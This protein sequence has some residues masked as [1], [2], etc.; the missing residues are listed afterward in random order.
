MILYMYFV[1]KIAGSDRALH[2]MILEMI[3]YFTLPIWLN[4]LIY[5]RLRTL[6]GNL[7]HWNLSPWLSAVNMAPSIVI[8]SSLSSLIPLLSMSNF[9]KERKSL[10]IMFI[11]G[12]AGSLYLACVYASQTH[13]TC[14]LVRS[15]SQRMG[16]YPC[17]GQ[18]ARVSSLKS[19]LWSL[20]EPSRRVFDV[21]WAPPD[22]SCIPMIEELIPSREELPHPKEG[23]SH[24]C[25]N[26]IT[27]SRIL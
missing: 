11:S 2:K 14:V 15:V 5:Y 1:L 9:K 16:A 25:W 12:Y 4:T 13:C 19:Y 7:L 8:L 20:L 22:G 18:K 24:W 26:W 17:K 6:G 3:K 21:Y 23:V 10:K 27:S